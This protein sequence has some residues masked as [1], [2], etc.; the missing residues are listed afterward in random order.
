MDEPEAAQLAQRQPDGRQARRRHRRDRDVVEPRDA[1]PRRARRSRARP[2]APARPSASRSLA[3]A[4]AVNGASPASSVSTPRAPPAR[5]KVVRTTS[6]RSNGMPASARPMPV[7]G[8][9]VARDEQGAGPARNA[10][11]RCPSSTSAATIVAIPPALSTPTSGSPRGMR[12]QV[13]DRRA[14]GAHRGEVPVDLLVDRRVVEA[15]AREHDGRR[16]HGAQQPDVRALPLGIPL[17]A[18]G[19]DEVA[20]D[21]G[22][23]LHAAH[24]LG[25]VRVGDVVD[26]H[27]RPPASGS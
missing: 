11:R 19:D 4:I 22:R 12:R 16:A 25:E 5:S 7:A 24:D 9:P 13:D 2:A 6:A 21:R 15:A 3:Q 1:T 14:V 23:V 20:V 26:D 10:I 17:R 18:A 8:Q 27:A